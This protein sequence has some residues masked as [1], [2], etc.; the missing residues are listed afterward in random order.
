VPNGNT[1]Y[2]M[3]TVEDDT[4]TMRLQIM[5]DEYLAL[6]EIVHYADAVGKWFLWRGSIRDMKW[7][8][9]NIKQVRELT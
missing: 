1:L 4:G 6:D 9:I 3:L 8:N 2:V 7:R 5:R